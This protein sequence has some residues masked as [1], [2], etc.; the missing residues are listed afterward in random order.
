M[1]KINMCTKQT[2]VHAPHFLLRDYKRV[3][4]ITNQVHKS[5]KSMDFLGDIGIVLM[6]SIETSS[7]TCLVEGVASQT[8]LIKVELI[9]LYKPSSSKD[10]FMNNLR[11]LP[12]FR[13][14]P[15]SM[16]LKPSLSKV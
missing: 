1:K 16:H 8:E 2:K 14:P 11:P 9:S 12:I 5:R 3:W 13:T 10:H 6:P 4:L 7:S 15:S